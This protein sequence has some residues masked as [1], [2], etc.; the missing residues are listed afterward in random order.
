MFCL[1]LGVLL[2][3]L[4]SFCVLFYLMFAF[5]CVDYAVLV[6]L[7][8]VTTCVVV[9][10][11]VLFWLCVAVRSLCLGFVLLLC[12]LGV[13]ALLLVCWYCVLGVCDCLLCSLI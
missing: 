6:V 3:C 8:L 5:G 9:F 4:V 1:V 2:L 12:L 13:L 11:C 10:S 7:G